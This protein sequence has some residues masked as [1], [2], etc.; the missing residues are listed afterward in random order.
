MS[1]FTDR[2][3]P[4]DFGI[5]TYLDN[6][7]KNLY[8]IPTFQRNVVWEK[9]HVKKLWDTIYKFYPMGSILVWKTDIQ[10]QRHR[11]IGGHPISDNMISGDCQY[12][13]DGQQ[14]TTALMTSLYGGKIA[15]Q[16][17]FDPTL[18]FDL[19]IPDP[20]DLDETSYRERFVFWNEID[21]QK[22]TQLRNIPRKKRFDEG[23]IVPLRDVYHQYGSVEGNLVKNGFADYEDPHRI[24]LRKM[25]EVLD[26]YRMAFIELKGI[27]VG[28]VCQIFERINQSGK[29]LSI[30]DIVVAKTFRVEKNGT[31]GFDLREMFDQFRNSFAGEYKRVDDLTILHMLAV[32]IREFVPDS[33]VMN[34]TDRYLNEIKTEYIETI[35]MEA[36]KAIKKVF[37]FLDNHMH[38]RGPELIPYRYFYM[39]LVCYFYGNNQPDYAFLKKYFWYYSFHEVNLLRSTTDL[40]ANIN[41]LV[42][43]RNTLPVTAFA[44]DKFLINKRTLRNASYSARSATSRAI[45][46]LMANQEPKDW[47][48]TDR[49]VLGEV[50]YLLTDKPNLH[51]IF[52]TNYIDKHP[53]S[54]KLTSNSL[55]NIA[56]ITQMTNL[57]ISDK[58]PVQYLQ[59]F[60]SSKLQTILDNHLIPPDLLNW[61]RQEQLPDDAL[62][63]FIELRVELILDL[64][65]QKLDGIVFDVI[66]TK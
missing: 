31:S 39:T 37:D 7:K 14:R 53:G 15:G 22:G 58:N 45:L 30:F 55:M 57:Q 18:Y 19:S 52:P 47:K 21:D 10:L 44:F 50:Y 61:S 38:F 4:T 56:Y 65:R 66:D 48:H 8:Q 9:E 25:K 3:R 5:S 23:L 2:I 43:C 17:D 36:T 28:E 32:L 60:D 12:I 51:H 35:W 59:E 16:E 27:Q 6:L 62:D 13:L 26:N 63:Q 64:L 40:K 29:P 34:I 54:N 42:P 24:R 41:D 11:Q 20:E 46:A 49:N 33:G 1:T